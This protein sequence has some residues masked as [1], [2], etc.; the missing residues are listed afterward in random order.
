MYGRLAVVRLLVDARSREIDSVERLFEEADAPRVKEALGR[1]YEEIRGLRREVEE[2]GATFAVVVFPFRVQVEPKAPSPVVQ[3]RIADFCRLEGLRCLDMLPTLT[4]KGPSAFVDYD[5]LSASGASLTADTILASGLLPDGYSNP[6]VLRRRFE[7]HADAGARQILAWL[8]APQ[9]GM[10]A[11]GI[12]ALVG[13]LDAGQMAA[14]A[15]AGGGR[16]IRMA[17]AW[18]LEALGPAAAAARP[19][20]AEALRGDSSTGVRAAAAEALGAM[21]AA[22]RGSVPALFD[23]L[24]DP[25]EAVRYTAA[26]ALSRLGPA[27]EDIPRLVA[28]LDSPDGYVAAFAAWSLGNLRAQARDAVPALVRVLDRDDTAVVA[29][30]ALAR[31]GPAAG[32]AVPS[33]VAALGSPNSGRRWRAAR[34]LGRIGPVAEAAVP[35]LAAALGDPDAWV[36]ANAAKALGR[37]GIA[38]RAA[39]PAL[40]RATGDPDRGVRREA[41]H[42]LDRLH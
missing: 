36:R 31:I 34:T 14:A 20:L 11:A 7:G 33:L 17:A 23:T 32:D 13:L 22:G 39:A 42:A 6:Q 9:R 12:G 3:E 29:A 38:A 40:Q 5:H 18:A 1:F 28:A 16:E 41:R 8:E 35:A 2:D 37:M 25:S 21:G 30:G 15:G 10:R 4:R 19:A 26:Q 24:G 27:P